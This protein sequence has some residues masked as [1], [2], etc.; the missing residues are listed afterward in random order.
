MST[1]IGFIL[2]PVW[3]VWRHCASGS[4]CNARMNLASFQA[5]FVA[6][7]RAITLIARTTDSNAALYK[8]HVEI[9]NRGV[10]GAPPIMGLAQHV[11]AEHN[12][13]RALWAAYKEERHA[14]RRQNLAWHITRE[15]SM[16]SVKEEMVIY[17]VVREVKKSIL[18]CTVSLQSCKTI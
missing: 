8:L 15:A 2:I 18:R 5:G 4:K 11:R 17:P 7:R 10:G 16:H 14:G 13:I 9:G 12:R 6:S 1:A 3:A